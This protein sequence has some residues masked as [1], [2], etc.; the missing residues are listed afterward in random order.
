M[1]TPI[2]I[3]MLAAAICACGN[4][5]ELSPDPEDGNR[6]P[7]RIIAGG[8][9]GDGPIDGVV[10]LYVIDDATRAPIPGASVRIGDVDGTTG[11]DGLFVA[12]GVVGPQTVSVKAGSYRSEVWIGADGANMTLSLVKADPGAAPSGVLQG[13]I[14]GFAGLTVP[15]GHAK[16]AVIV[17]SQTGD[18]GDP[19]NELPNT[20]N[21]CFVRLAGQDC[22]FTLTAR[23]GKVALVAAIFDRDLKGTPTVFTDDTVT[24]IGW[25]TRR[26]VTVSA[27]TAPVPGMDLTLLGA[28]QLQ[29][30]SV[31]FG[32]PPSLQAVAGLVGL[33]L[34]DEGVLQLP[35]VVTK[36]ASSLLVPRLE[37][38]SASGYRLTGIATEGQ[39]VTQQSVVLRKGQTG[40]QLSAGAWLAIP[41]G[42]TADRAGAS[43][44][45]VAGATVHSVEYKSGA[46]RVLNVTV[47]DGSSRVTVPSLIALPTGSLS[48][49]VNAI[50]A[51][52]LDVTSFS[53]DADEDKLV[54]VG[55]RTV[56]LD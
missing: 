32:A 9:I 30:V 52:G 11:A 55:G 47:L 40:T 56:Q 20:M 51:P 21:S 35:T 8:G 24:L 33:D 1:R 54:Q 2:L 23:T 46:T 53:L 31:D 4:D 5:E 36:A 6:P 25:A 22:P 13:Q 28:G 39:P 38:V 49:A 17:A 19:G 10:N 43:W 15:A 41:A 14:A 50:G 44:T 3:S 42:V 12:E 34:G 7:P 37:A 18:L 48:I 45:P 27:G 16:D 26:G 29:T